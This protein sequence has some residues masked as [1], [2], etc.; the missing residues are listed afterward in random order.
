MQ[1]R[2]LNVVVATLTSSEVLNIIFIKNIGFPRMKKKTLG[3][4]I[5]LIF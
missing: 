5:P 4:P 2:E 3:L 1:S